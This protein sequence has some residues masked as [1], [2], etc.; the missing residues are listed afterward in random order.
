MSILVFILYIYTRIFNKEAKFCKMDPIFLSTT[1][2]IKPGRCLTEINVSSKLNTPIRTCVLACACARMRAHT[3]NL[4]KH[5][6]FLSTCISTLFLCIWNLEPNEAGLTSHSDSESAK[7]LFSQLP[8][9]SDEPTQAYRHH[10]ELPLGTEILQ[11]IQSS[12]TT[13]LGT[14]VQGSVLT[15]P[16]MHTAVSIIRQ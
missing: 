4:I 3:G 14:G 6:F 12:T 5:L 8:N 10:P 11:R 7:N 13:R 1:F 2:I 15:V 16:R 9:Q